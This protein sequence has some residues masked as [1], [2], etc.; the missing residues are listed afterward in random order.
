MDQ[1]PIKTNGMAIAAMIL[2]IVGIVFFWLIVPI[3][4][5]ILALIFGI[6]SLN[7]IKTTQQPGKGMAIAGI[8]MGAI[9]IVILPF[10]LIGMIAYMGVLNP[11]QMM[12]PKCTLSGGFS[13]LE[14]KVDNS[15]MNGNTKIFMKVQNNLG[16]DASAITFALDSSDCTVVP[17]EQVRESMQ[18][19]EIFLMSFDC[20]KQLAKAGYFRGDITVTYTKQ[21]ETIPHQALGAISSKIE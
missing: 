10:V 18:N 8:I 16:N 1:Q 6:I 21:G 4:C 13:C 15:G 5:L 14:F 17:K 20:N 7:K 2:G 12:P 3:I 19:G 11:G 9:G